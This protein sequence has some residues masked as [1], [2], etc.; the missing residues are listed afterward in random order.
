MNELWTERWR[1]SK[2]EDCILSKNLKD[3]FAKFVEQKYVPN[4]LLS[5]TAGVG[6]TTVARAMLEECGFDYIVINGSLNGNIDTLRVEIKNFASTVSFTGSRKYVILDEADY[7]QPQ[8]TQPGLRNFMEEYSNNCGFILTCNFKNRIIPPLHS[9]CA[10]IDF[11]IPNNEKPFL[12]Q[13]FMKRAAMILK[14]ENITFDPRVIAELITKYF[15]DWRRSLNELQRYSVNGTIDV[16]I[17]VNLSDDNLKPLIGFLKNK[18][19]KEMRKWVA[20]NTDIEPHVLYRKL[21]DAAS[22]NVAPKSIPQLVLH[23]ANYSYKSAFVADQ[24]INLVACLTEIMA[25][26][27]F[28]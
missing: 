26:C 16:G 12:A 4:L 21:Y 20:T 7:L 6:K 15:P 2:I 23:L 3:T 28:I 10:V 27:E 17:L 9:R 25:D 8:S 18:S 11:V 5:G 22:E 13:S 1:P 14:S 19:F 24:E